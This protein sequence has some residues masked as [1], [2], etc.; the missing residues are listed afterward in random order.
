M[1]DA[2]VRNYDWMSRVTKAAA[3]C[4][5]GA[6]AVWRAYDR[7]AGMNG[8]YALVLCILFAFSMIGIAV[9]LVNQEQ[10]GQVE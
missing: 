7:L 2:F 10:Q 6:G 9:S 4:V 1:F 3:C 5:V 8:L